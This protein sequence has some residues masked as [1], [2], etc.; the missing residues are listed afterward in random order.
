MV[1]LLLLLVN[2]GILFPD[3]ISLKQ[4]RVTELIP[5]PSLRP[6]PA[7]IKVVKPAVKPETLLPPAPRFR[8]AQAGGPAVL[9]FI[10][11]LFPNRLK[12]PRS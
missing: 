3:R 5:M 1:V 7:P 6:E 8:T 2:L 12:P 9:R 4:Y 11:Y 10:A